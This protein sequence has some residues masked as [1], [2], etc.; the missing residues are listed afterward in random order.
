MTVVRSNSVNHQTRYELRDD[1]GL[2]AALVY[3]VEEGEPAAWKILR[4]SPDGFEDLYGARQSTDP[5]ADWLKS[6]LTPIIGVD[7][8]AELTAAVDAS[9]PPAAAWRH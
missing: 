8:A 2:A 4:P 9:P 7:Q 5:D 1:T 6:W 3:A